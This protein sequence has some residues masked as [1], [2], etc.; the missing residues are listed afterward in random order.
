MSRSARL[1]GTVVAL[2]VAVGLGVLAGAV[3]GHHEPRETLP[4]DEANLEAA[5]AST[6]GDRVQAAIDGVQETG[7][8]VGPELRGRLSANEVARIERIID[9]APVPLYVV[10]WSQTYDGGYNTPYAA[11]DQLRAGVGTDGF[12]AVVTDGGNPLTE[13]VGYEWPYVE[14]DAKGRPG[15]ALERYVT[16]LAAVPPVREIVSE[17]SDWD[18]WGGPGGGFAAGLLFAALGYLG[19]MGLLAIVALFAPRRTRPGGRA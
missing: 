1:A 18:Y 16:E 17:D 7:F 12:Y 5:R 2:I 8:Y 10:W 9:D 14:A 15:P 3:P 19:L 13:A 11:L 4:F 6:P